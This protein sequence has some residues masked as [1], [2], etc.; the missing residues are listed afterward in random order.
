MATF[1][2]YEIKKN[3][4][5]GLKVHI[6]VIILIL[7][8]PHQGY[9]QYWGS[10]MMDSHSESL[11]NGT[12]GVLRSSKQVALDGNN[13]LITD[14]RGLSIVDVQDPSSPTYIGLIGTPGK[15]NR[16]VVKN[17]YAYI[18]D[19]IGMSIVNYSDPSML[20]VESFTPTNVSAHDIEVHENI[21][22]LSTSTGLIVFDVI[23]PSTPQQVTEIFIDNH[24][25]N[26]NITIHPDGEILYY[27]TGRHLY[28]INITSVSQPQ[29]IASLE[30]NPSTS[31]PGTCHDGPKLSG[32]FLYI[33]VT[34]ALHIYNIANPLQPTLIYEGIPFTPGTIY[35]AAVDGNLF[36]TG[37]WNYGGFY[38]I[39]V[40]NPASPQL[41][42]MYS[43]DDYGH[44]HGIGIIRDNKFYLLNYQQGLTPNAGWRLRIFD[45]TNPVAMVQLGFIDSQNA[46]YALVHSVVSKDNKY[47][48]LVGQDNAVLNAGS[49]T[50]SGLF[51]VIDVTDPNNPILRS[52][53][54]I[55]RVCVAIAANENVAVI[56][57]YSLGAL[58]YQHSLYLINI[59]DV[60]NPLLLS[61][62]D[63][64]AQLTNDV[65]TS[66]YIYENKLYL[67]YASGL[68]IFDIV[69][70][71]SIE[72]AG[73]VSIPQQA[74]RGI[75][76]KSV[77]ANVIAYVAAAGAGFQIYNVTNPSN[78]FL[79]A[80]HQAQGIAYDVWVDETY[81]YVSLM[82]GGFQI[83]DI[84]GG[85]AI[86]IKLVT[87][88]GQA[89]NIVVENNLAFVNLFGTA[90]QIA[91]QVFDISNRSNPENLGTYYTSGANNQISISHKGRRLYVSDT[92]SFN[93]Y[94][95]LFNFHPLSFQLSTP[96][97]GSTISANTT[98]TWYPA[99]DANDDPIT[100][101][102]SVWNDHWD[103]TV[104][105]ILDTFYNSGTGLFQNEGIYKWTVRGTDGS[106]YVTSTDTFE[107]N[108]IIT[109]IGSDTYAMPQSFELWQNYPNPFNPSTQIKFNLPVKSEISISVFNNLGET[110]Q[111]L[112]RGTKPAGFHSVTWNAASHSTKYVPSGVYFIRMMAKAVDSDKNFTQ[113]IKAILLK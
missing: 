36:I 43:V 19:Q 71:S 24:N 67:V 72:L 12:I 20:L 85:M 109:N 46:G 9:A 34:T 37:P 41:I 76:V 28:V 8:F 64:P 33:P 80:F 55:P 26:H 7:G 29:I 48:A 32:D 89:K 95:P 15:S 5:N 79:T 53:L 96:E 112:Y 17:G 104:I 3:L 82:S 58:N 102:L 52:T 63:I 22:F 91:I 81:A 13:L 38:A 45:T 21:A 35:S 42:Q 47:Y 73:V 83:Y 84:S 44:G 2:K 108:Y 103:T 100:Y 98:F 60:N 107:V 75:K 92:Y 97:N 39:N 30:F 56:R 4:I 101:E 51:R 68:A 65:T 27:T 88:Q 40:Q 90:S 113:T 14:S 93:I 59:E 66:M 69:A 10:Q 31:V 111:E 54:E 23:N 16:L 18:A 106:V 61:I 87:T 11:N 110:I 57:G 74:V 6:L 105:N 49:S 77:G 78:I 86:P 25:S 62:Y 70:N 94:R 50:Y 99:E 1:L